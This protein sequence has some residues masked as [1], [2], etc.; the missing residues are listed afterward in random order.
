MKINLLG[1]I[2]IPN[3]DGSGPNFFDPVRIIFLLLRPGQPPPGSRKF[4]SKLQ[5]F[6]FFTLGLGQK[7]QGQ[8][9]ARVGLSLS[10]L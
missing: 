3:G 8:K 7:N 5:I 1:T 10:H 2:S 9:Y 4:H 6:Q